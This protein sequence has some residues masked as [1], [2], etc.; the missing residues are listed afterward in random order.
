MTEPWGGWVCDGGPLDGVRAEV[1]DDGRIW[2]G[3][4]VLFSGYRGGPRAPADGWFRT[5]DL[6]LLDAE[7]RLAVRGRADDVINTG[8]DK[9][10]PGGGAAAFARWPGVPEG[11]GG[12]GTPPGKGGRGA[13]GG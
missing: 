5:G 11:G 3:G 9:G 12:G 8:G 10:N 6:G 7:G 2:L 4:P 13:A 1:R